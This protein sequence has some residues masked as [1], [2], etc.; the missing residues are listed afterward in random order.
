MPP[1]RIT[2]K[3]ETDGCGGSH[4]IPVDKIPSPPPKI[5]DAQLFGVRDHKPGEQL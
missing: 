4:K 1:G 2:V 5:A 3:P